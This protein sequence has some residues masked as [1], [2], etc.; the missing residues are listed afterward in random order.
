MSS[1][2]CMA[3]KIKKR[4]K[5]RLGTNTHKAMINKELAM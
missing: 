5:K 3:D 4:M 2:K 1:E